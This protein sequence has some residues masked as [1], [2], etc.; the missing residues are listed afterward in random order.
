MGSRWE[1]VPLE[2]GLGDR[3]GSKASTRFLLYHGSPSAARARPTAPA[4]TSAVHLPL[5]ARREVTPALARSSPRTSTARATATPGCM[6]HP[7]MPCWAAGPTSC[8]AE[9]CPGP[10]LP[11]DVLGQ[12]LRRSRHLRPRRS[13]CRAARP[14]PSSAAPSH[15]NGHVRGYGVNSSRKR[16]KFFPSVFPAVFTRI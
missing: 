14:Q 5:P 13:R 3:Y 11:Q 12:R 10:S 6:H 4:S 15:A 7:A 1:G 16:G 9:R 2:S 8:T